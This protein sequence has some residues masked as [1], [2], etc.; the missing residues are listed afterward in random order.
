MN[1]TEQLRHIRETVGMAEMAH[2]LGIHAFTYYKWV[3]G[4]SQP[5][6]TNRKKIEKVY[7]EL[8]EETGGGVVVNTKPEA[9]VNTARKI[10]MDRF[11]QSVLSIVIDRGLHDRLITLLREARSVGMTLEHLAMLLERANAAAQPQL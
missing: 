8:V 10:A 1:L 7:A 4:D 3:K 11:V 2:R 6:E 9:T 5:T